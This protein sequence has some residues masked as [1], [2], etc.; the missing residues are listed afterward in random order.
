MLVMLIGAGVNKERKS[1]E[2]TDTD[3]QYGFDLCHFNESQL[4]VLSSKAKPFTHQLG[5][6]VK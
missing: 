4:D 2:K 6:Y 5:M 3:E 1:R